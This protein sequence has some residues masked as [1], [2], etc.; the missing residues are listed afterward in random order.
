[1]WK[2]SSAFFDAP[3]FAVRISV[4]FTLSVAFSGVPESTPS[5]VRVKPSGSALAASTWKSTLSRTSRFV[6]KSFRS[7]ASIFL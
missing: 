5:A 4:V 2:V 1:M 7:S 6:T 3:F